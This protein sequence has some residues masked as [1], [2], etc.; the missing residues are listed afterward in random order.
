MQYGDLP[1]SLGII[2]VNCVE[3]MFYQ[4]LPIKLSGGINIQVE[5]RLLCFSGL[6]GTACGDYIWTFGVDNFRDCNIYITAKRLY[7]KP[8]CPINRPGYHSDGFMTDD[9]NYIWSDKFPT[10]FNTSPYSLTMHHEYS[11]SEMELQSLVENEVRY[12]E[13]ELLRL[14][15]F[16]IHKVARITELALRTF[17]KISFS[18]EQYNLAGNSRNYL[19]KYDWEMKAREDVRNHPVKK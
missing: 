19:L 10:V 14:N 6:I 18:K 16:S 5:D 11:L 12:K 4:Y 13:N 1:I 17:V 8:G 3:M 7:A 2:D 15:Q 9:I